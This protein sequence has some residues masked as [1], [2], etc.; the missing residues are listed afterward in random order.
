[1]APD[2]ARSPASADDGRAP[3]LVEPRLLVRGLTKAYGRIR[4]LDALDL[5]I[6]A[7]TLTA[8]VGSNG[9][10]KST[11]L[12]CLAGVLRHGGS[13]SFDG[14]PL[15]PLSGRVA[16]LPQRI[17][18]PGSATVDEVLNLFRSLAGP[19]ADRTAPPDGFVPPGHRRIAELSGG[20]AQRV[21]LAA[22]LLGTPELLLLDEP[23]ANLDDD[24]RDVV[25]EMLAAH[26]D[27][28]AA[29]LV[30]SPAAFDLLAGADRVIRVE[31]GRI[32][33][34]GAAPAYLAG[35]R[36]TVWV[37]L[38]SDAN[39]S[40][41][42]DIAFVERTRFA[43]RWAALECRERDVTTVLHTLGDR[44]IAA[45]RIWIAGPGDATVAGSPPNGSPEASS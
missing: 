6:P 22:T 13:I 2:A 27:A 32:V 3:G 20:Q 34:D 8:V 16:Y 42:T 29:I 4:V 12:G 43:G 36:T 24:A 45:D 7:A 1:M 30:A 9:A 35:L 23:L 15:R 38:E 41:F 39:G 33:F 5:T 40:A 21:A 37:A 44:G 31:A 26:R 11:L 19:S 18:L 25:R 10:G 28:G 17:R 14:P